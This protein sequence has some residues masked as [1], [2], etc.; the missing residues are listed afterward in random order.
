MPAARNNPVSRLLGKEIKAQ[1]CD[2]KWHSLETIAIATGTPPKDVWSILDRMCRWGTYKTKCERKKVGTAYQYRLSPKEKQISPH[3][4]RE[5]LTPIVKELKIHGKSNAA[6]WSA[7][8]VLILA[9]K[10][11]KLL[12]E[13][14]E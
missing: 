8:S 14:A 5:R 12:D 1:F 4:L 10:I 9:A 6:T 11:Q 13:W 3:E 2:G 7:P